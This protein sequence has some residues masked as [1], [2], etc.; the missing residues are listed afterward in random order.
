MIRTCIAVYII[1]FCIY[2][3]LPIILE[4]LG[5]K[6]KVSPLLLGSLSIIF[7][8]ITFFLF[9]FDFFKFCSEMIVN[10]SKYSIS[11]LICS[12]F[13]CLAAPILI[14]GLLYYIIYKTL[15]VDVNLIESA[16]I[17]LY[18][19]FPSELSGSKFVIS[20]YVE[21]F[22]FVQVIISKIVELLVISAIVSKAIPS[23][24]DQDITIEADSQQ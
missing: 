7:I 8:A 6:Q 3:L 19:A 22:S 5:A 17:S 20:I 10:A 14:F 11:K 21:Y 1:I 12:L 9:I 16:F 24:S 2:D 15:N 13:L 18:V 23:P 4:C